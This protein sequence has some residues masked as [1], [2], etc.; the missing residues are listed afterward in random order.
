MKKL[1]VFALIL[2][3]FSG[4][5]QSAEEEVDFLQS[6]FGMEKKEAVAG[7]IKLDNAKSESFWELYDEYEADRKNLGKK[8][9]NLLQNYANNY[10]NMSNEDIDL[11]IKESMTLSGKT[12]KLINSYYKKIHKQ[13]GSVPAAQF[14]QIENYL[15]SEIRAAILGEMDMIDIKN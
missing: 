10:E 7:M 4:Y 11:L 1:L 14:Y 9:I 13:V 6:I 2:S 12:D 8:R 3:V 15:L 5:S